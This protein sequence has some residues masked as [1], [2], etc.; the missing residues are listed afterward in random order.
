[1]ELNEA[2]SIEELAEMALIHL[3]DL[4]GDSLLIVHGDEDH[5][6]PVT[7]VFYEL[8]YSQIETELWE[9]SSHDWTLAPVQAK[10]S[11]AGQ[12]LTAALLD[13]AGDCLGWLHMRCKG[14]FSVSAKAELTRFAS[15][16]L[17]RLLEICLLRANPYQA[18]PL[19]VVQSRS[20]LILSRL[21]LD[22]SEDSFESFEGVAG[23]PS[24]PGRSDALLQSK[25]TSGTYPAGSGL[26]AA[27]Q[28]S[29]DSIPTIVQESSGIPEWEEEPPGEVE[30]VEEVPPV[31]ALMRISEWQF[32][33]DSEW[34]DLQDFVL[35]DS[36]I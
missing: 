2:D 35:R 3:Q 18:E 25:K 26:P 28:D 13:R 15:N 20:S 36:P 30:E 7:Q 5:A 34:L 8:D 11:G 10:Q 16:Y 29:M 24:T 17:D 33:M 21:E 27:T 23:E 12:A 14:R 4:G 1:M 9:W 32:N 31:L 6:H 22:D 19:E